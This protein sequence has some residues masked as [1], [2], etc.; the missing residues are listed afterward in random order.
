MTD[1]TSIDA[2]AIETISRLQTMNSFIV[3]RLQ[4]MIAQQSAVMEENSSTII[5]LRKEMGLMIDDWTRRRAGYMESLQS[6]D[7]VIRALKDRILQLELEQ[8]LTVRL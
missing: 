6:K 7:D 3:T 4:D 1:P 5:R 2:E 8:Y